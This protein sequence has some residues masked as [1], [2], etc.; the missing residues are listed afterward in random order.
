MTPVAT[1]L[2]ASLI[3]VASTCSCA[4]RSSDPSAANSLDEAIRETMTEARRAVEELGV[5]E[6]AMQRIQTALSRLARTPRLKERSDF[7][8]LHGGGAAAAVLASD[9]KDDLTL[10]LTRFQPGKTTPIHDHGTWAVAYVVEGPERYIQWERLDDGGDPRRAE[11]QVKYERILR[12]GDALYWFDPPHDIHSQEAME[13][14]AWE[15]LLFGRNPQQRTLHYF[16]L[17]TGRVT[18]K[19]PVTTVGAHERDE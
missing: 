11:L 13:G 14:V 4:G 7:R 16:D 17:G 3:V 5:T 2:V 9:G 18:T 8:E 12:P 10:I 15:L 1:K 19:A 6:A